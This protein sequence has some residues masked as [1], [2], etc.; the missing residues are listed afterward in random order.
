MTGE[1]CELLVGG[2]LRRDPLLHHVAVPKRKQHKPQPVLHAAAAV[3]RVVAVVRAAEI[4]PIAF[5]KL[6]HR[7][8]LQVAGAAVRAALAEVRVVGASDGPAVHLVRHAAEQPFVH[9]SLEVFVVVAAV[10]SFRFECEGDHPP[11][12]IVHRGAF[13]PGRMAMLLNCPRSNSG[14]LALKS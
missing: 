4:A 1:G 8:P 5:G 6:L 13:L 9:P 10:G 11:E 12:L 7:D 3:T 14:W 2:G